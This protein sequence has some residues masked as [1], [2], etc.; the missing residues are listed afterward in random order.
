MLKYEEINHACPYAT[1]TELEFARQEA[2]KLNNLNQIV[3]LG[4]GP[5]VFGLAMLEGHPNPPKMAIVDINT[6]Y[7]AEA[8]MRGA[9]IDPNK[10]WFITGDSSSVGKLWTGPIDLL[11]IDADHTYSGVI[12]DIRAW[13][14]HLKTDG[15][16]IFHDYLYR[17][18]GFNGTEEWHFQDVY[19]AIEDSRDSSWV[20]VNQVGIS[21]VYM[22]V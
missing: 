5:C 22:K 16:C 3:M 7:Y 4:C 8:H 9:G 15:L 13:W 11:V 21:A 6:F 17:D 18:G 14:S 20:L 19:R 12:K 1:Q 10:V 2:F